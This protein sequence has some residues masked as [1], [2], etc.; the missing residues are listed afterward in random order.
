MISTGNGHAGVEAVI[1][2]D[3]ASALL[4]V[5]LD[6]DFLALATDVDAVYHGWGT[7]AQRAVAG[8][9]PQW[10]RANPFAAGSMGPKV[11]AVCR[12]VE[13]TGNR[14]AIG[15]LEQLS[16]LIDGTAGTQIRADGPDV[17]FRS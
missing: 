7:P 14:A 17:E 16:G 1:D 6:A 2:K 13:Q 3:L 12:F 10:P 9:T 11:E 4:A 8:A 5:G 15:Q